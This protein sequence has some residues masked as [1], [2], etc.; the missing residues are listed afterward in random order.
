MAYRDEVTADGPLYWWKL[1]EVAGASAAE[2]VSGIL[3]GTYVNTPTLGD[4]A[5]IGAGTAVSVVAASSEEI[6]LPITFTGDFTFEF[7]FKWSSGTS[8]LRFSNS[9]GGTIPLWV[10]GSSLNVRIDGGD[11]SIEGGDVAA[12]VIR[13][14]DWHHYVMRRSGST[15]SV[16]INGIKVLEQTVTTGTIGTSPL[17]LGRNGTSTPYS[18][19]TFDEVAYYNSALSDARIAAHFAASGIVDTSDARLWREYAGALVGGE[20]SRAQLWREYAGA[21]VGGET[22]EGRLWRVY[23]EALQQ[24][25]DTE[26]QMWRSYAEVLVIET[27]PGDLYVREGGVAVLRPL[28]LR[29]AGAAVDVALGARVP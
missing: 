28:K 13:D 7:L 6:T 18:N 10:N 11:Y 12:S 26:A 29:V 1:D 5:V 8:L 9:A 16:W 15:A 17:R 4:T 25:V 27:P 20:A 24:A 3:N 23:G 21:L 14:G 2:S 19:A 22:S